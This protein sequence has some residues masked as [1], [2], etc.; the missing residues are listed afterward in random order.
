MARSPSTP[1]SS[2]DNVTF[3]PVSVRH[4]RGRERRH[5]PPA[6]A[7]LNRIRGEFAEMPGLSL[8]EAQASRLLGVPQELCVRSLR[9]LVDQGILRLRR[10][11][12]YV[13]RTTAA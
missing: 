3:K 7:V 10:D 12:R 11:G 4:L 8:T 9:H 2:F 13:L 1:R 6:P 5:D